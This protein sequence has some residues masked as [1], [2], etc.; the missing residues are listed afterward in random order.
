MAN[1]DTYEDGVTSVVFSPNSN[2]IFT[3]S[4][5]GTAKVWDLQGKP[6]ID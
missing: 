5:D 3:A 4:W 6:L 2:R 1:F